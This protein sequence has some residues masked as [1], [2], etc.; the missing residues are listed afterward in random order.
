MT[1]AG[2]LQRLLIV[3]MRFTLRLFLGYRV[4]GQ[5]NYK[6]L[7]PP[8]IIIANH[9]SQ[10][11]PFLLTPAFPV[12]SKIL[13]IR[14]VAKRELFDKPSIRKTFVSALG[15]FK[16]ERGAGLEKTLEYPLQLLKN[17][18][19]VAIFPTGMREKPYGRPR[20]ARR[21]AAYLALK[22]GVP[23]LTMYVRNV[24]G[25]TFENFIKLR[26]RGKKATIIIM[27]PF[28]LPKD[29][30]DPDDHPNDL[31]EARD[32]IEKALA[33]IRKAKVKKTNNPIEEWKEWIENEKWID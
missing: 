9:I 32:I 20:K 31:D 27:P 5:K 10:G 11:D 12:F 15:G 17:G 2:F 30:K 6:N 14:F 25:I 26:A 19:V 24:K 1:I 3:P 8:F 18:K 7:K 21:G 22:T 23:I 4:I 16:V 29:L 28:S 33:K 13:P